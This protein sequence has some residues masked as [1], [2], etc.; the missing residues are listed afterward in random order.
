[1]FS[2]T[3]QTRVYLAVK[4]VDMRK[5]FD[6]LWAE[7]TRALGSDPFAGTLFVFSNKKRNLLKILH[8]DGSGVCVL[9]KRLEKGRFSW[10][11]GSDPKKL[12]ITPQALGMILGGID[13]K[14]GAKKGWF[15]R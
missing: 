9:G 15:E 6:G 11:K 12:S 5:S 2:F 3:N 13:L 4:P 10:P 1:M 14:D 8:W 7:A